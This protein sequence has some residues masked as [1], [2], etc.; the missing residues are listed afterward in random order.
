MDKDDGRIYIS[1][2]AQSQLKALAEKFHASEEYVLEFLIKDR[3]SVSDPKKNEE[4]AQKYWTQ[5]CNEH[6][7]GKLDPDEIY[8]AGYEA[9]WILFQTRHG[10]FRYIIAP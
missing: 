1:Y 2:E 4:R 6:F 8:K 9:G 3:F 7:L 10:E 5:F